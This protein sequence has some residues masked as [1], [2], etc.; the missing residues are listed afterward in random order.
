MDVFM[1]RENLK[2]VGGRLAIAKNDAQRQ[3]L[4]R[5]IA[6]EEANV[7]VAAGQARAAEPEAMAGTKSPRRHRF[8]AVPLFCGPLI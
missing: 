1:C 7:P 8:Q 6:E 4:L 2:V 3:L 5:L